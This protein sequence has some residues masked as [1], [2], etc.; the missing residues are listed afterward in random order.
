MDA[1]LE[2]AGGV[3]YYPL[4][5]CRPKNIEVPVNSELDKNIDEAEKLI[6]K[7][8]AEHKTVS[9][10]DLAG[11]DRLLLNIEAFSPA[12]VAGLRG[13]YFALKKDMKKAT[14]WHEKAVVEAQAQPSAYMRYADSLSYLSDFRNSCMLYVKAA[15]AAGVNTAEAREPLFRALA[16]AIIE[17][18]KDIVE[19]W[20]PVFTSI[21][22]TD[23][24]LLALR[25][26][27]ESGKNATA[28]YSASCASGV[29][30]DWN[31]P[32]EDEAWQHLQ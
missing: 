11:L 28:C 16:I 7:L 32:D 17:R 29:L 25:K 31:H 26:K 13:A 23:H 22:G 2:R 3:Y 27:V 12:A 4:W 1:A 24:M 20:L 19:Q 21:H 14:E 18:Y 9:D 30:D 8:F 15:E 5:Q 6:S 10:K